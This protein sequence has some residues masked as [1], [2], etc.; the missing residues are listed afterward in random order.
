M[1]SLDSVYNLISLA[2]YLVVGVLLFFTPSGWSSLD[3]I[4]AMGVMVSIIVCTENRVKIRKLERNC[5]CV[6]SQEDSKSGGGAGL[7]FDEADK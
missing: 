4:L 1:S 2:S 7:S 5:T 6:T 3:R